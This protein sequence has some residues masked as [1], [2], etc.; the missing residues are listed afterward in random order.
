MGNGGRG[1]SP[2][3]GLRLRHCCSLKSDRLQTGQS[4]PSAHEQSAG[5]V[6]ERL[7]YQ[8]GINANSHVGPAGRSTLRIEHMSSPFAVALDSKETISSL[9]SRCLDRES[10]SMVYMALVATSQ[11]LLHH[12]RQRASN[13]RHIQC[14]G[15]LA[16]SSEA[17]PAAQPHSRADRP[18]QLPTVSRGQILKGSLLAAGGLLVGSV[19]PMG[20]VAVESVE[21]A[22]PAAAVFAT[23]AAAQNFSKASRAVLPTAEPWLVSE[24]R[25]AC[26]TC[27][28]HHRL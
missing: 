16:H 21:A 18:Q 17:A 23:P 24:P 2:G 28:C 8:E 6:N 5:S 25:Y 22:Q 15:S 1:N 20:A 10:P 11:Q 9:F 26:C 7:V 19:V 14:S 3:R 4:L 27:L 12:Q 13:C